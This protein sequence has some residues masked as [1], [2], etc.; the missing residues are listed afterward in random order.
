MNILKTSLIA[1]L[2]ISAQAATGLG[3]DY[4]NRKNTQYACELF[5][6]DVYQASDNF[7]SGV[8]LR[9]LL[10]L[11]EGAPVPH[12]QKHRAFQ[13]IKFVWNNEL[14]NPVLA[15]TL[16]MGLC[17]KPKQVMAPLDEPYL[18]SPRTS[19]EYF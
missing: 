9:D 15:S 4:T 2:L 10:D 13:A 18:T 3:S 5:A 7:N 16:A 8:V 11:M 17:L 6:R 1:W 14:D 12:S 19:K